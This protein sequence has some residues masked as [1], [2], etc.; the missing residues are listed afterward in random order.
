MPVSGLDRAQNINTHIET[1][2]INDMKKL[3][4]TFSAECREY[5]GLFIIDAYVCTHIDNLPVRENCERLIKLPKLNCLFDTGSNHS[6]INIQAIKTLQLVPSSDTNTLVTPNAVSK[7]RTYKT[8]IFFPGELIFTNITVGEMNSLIDMI[9]GTDVIRLG[10]F[11]LEHQNDKYIL[12]FSGP[13]H[14]FLP[15]EKLITG[16]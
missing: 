4:R 8:D 14:L 9:I 16:H 6:L 3:L 12:S 5:C 7:S 2:G 15:G 13:G 1:E 10:D 11:R